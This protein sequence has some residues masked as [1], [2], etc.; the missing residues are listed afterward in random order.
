MKRIRAYLTQPLVVFATM[1]VVALLIMPTMWQG[2]QASKVRA[3]LTTSPG[4]KDNPELM[5]MAMS[6]RTGA[7]FSQPIDSPWGR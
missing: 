2:V 3:N 1:G 7:D 5:Q 6:G 4:S